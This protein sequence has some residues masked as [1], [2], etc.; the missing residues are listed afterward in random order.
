MTNAGL[1]L[2]SKKGSLFLKFY[3]LLE[4]LSFIVFLKINFY[5]I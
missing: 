1:F 2:S 3:D 4:G 5:N